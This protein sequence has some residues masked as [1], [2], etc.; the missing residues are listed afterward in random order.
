M[1]GLIKKVFFTRLAF[2]STLTSVNFL[3]CISM[4]NQNSKV[5]S[6]IANLNRNEPMFFS[7]NTETSKCGGKC[8]NIN[9]PYAKLCVPDVVKNL[10]VKVFNLMSRTNE[11]KDIEWHET[12]KFECRLDASVC[13]KKQ[14]R[15]GDKC[16]CECKE[17]IDK[18]VRNE[19]AIWNPRNCECECDK[20]SDTGNI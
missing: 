10:N 20:S 6:Q 7:F 19:G 5:R 9:N 11:T 13:N 14:R 4:N 18:G 15:N 17:L 12:C 8:S 1:F 3:S 16:R 2:L